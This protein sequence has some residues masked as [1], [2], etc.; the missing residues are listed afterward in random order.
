MV[1]SY[2]LNKIL[3]LQSENLHIVTIS[4]KKNNNKNSNVRSKLKKKSSRV[5]C[6]TFII[7]LTRKLSYS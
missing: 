1:K 7:V 2:L 4:K 5:F 6:E 3:K